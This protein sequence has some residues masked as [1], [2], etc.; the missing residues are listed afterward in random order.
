VAAIQHTFTHPV[1]AVQHTFTHPVAA[2]QHTFTHKQYTKY[3]ERRIWEVQA[4]S[5]LCQ[6][7]PGICLTT[8]EKAHKTLSQGSSS[9]PQADTAQYK[10]NEE[11]WLNSERPC[12]AIHLSGNLNLLAEH[13]E[14]L[15]IWLFFPKWTEN[16][17]W[18]VRSF[19]LTYLSL[20]PTPKPHN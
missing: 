6:L 15:S 19:P 1:A 4:V 14:L 13:S 16:A 8:E 11:A 2:V 18:C 9:T 7:Y 17:W 5:R 3:R 12:S 10:N 20:T